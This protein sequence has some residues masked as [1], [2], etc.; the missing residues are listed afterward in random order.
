MPYGVRATAGF[1]AVL[2]SLASVAIGV[3]AG[4]SAGAA[5]THGVSMIG[6]SFSPKSVT[7]QPGD[8]VTWTNNSG[9]T[10]TVTADDGSFD[11]G[12]VAPGQTF[13]H[14]FSTAGT[15]EYHCSFHGAAGGI[16]MA[17][18]V[19]VQST[20]PR[21]TAPPVTTPANAPPPGSATP[22]T[23]PAAPGVAVTPLPSAV[24]PTG[25]APAATVADAPATAAQPQLART[26]SDSVALIAL[27]AVLMVTG[28]MAF[29]TG[30]RRSRFDA[31][32]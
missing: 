29:V 21:T 13:S 22:T 28:A 3:A 25:P 32:R 16:G 8:T 6:V 11:S 20:A 10:H 15:V 26:G 17:G 24:P 1:G 5:T 12:S 18:T 2:F 19:V 14:T 31:P 7:L 4:P 30:R 23:A 9:L 27:A